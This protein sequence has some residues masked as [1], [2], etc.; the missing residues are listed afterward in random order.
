MS[1]LPKSPTTPAERPATGL[2]G[3]DVASTSMPARSDLS[4]WIDLME[5]IEALC[6]VWPEHQTT[7][8]GIFR[9]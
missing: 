6:P 1:C 8:P 3:Q 5:V 7:R 4:D 9:L 2:L